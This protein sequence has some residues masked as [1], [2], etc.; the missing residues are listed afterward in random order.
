MKNSV[1]IQQ[2]QEMTRS[3]LSARLRLLNRMVNS[4]YDG[5]LREYSIKASQVSILAM[6]V[7]LG[8]AHC[9]ELCCR[10]QMDSSTF[11]RA[12]A[13]LRKSGW[14]KS[15]ASGD[16][17]ILKIT[18]TKEGSELLSQVYPLWKH[19]QDEAF[20]FLGEK[21]AEGLQD[22]RVPGEKSDGTLALL[23]EKDNYQIK[24]ADYE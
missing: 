13:R 20:A 16:G 4:I 3:C 14:L 15:E 2:V 8:E 9:K 5:A 12:L 11:S 23:R 6:V 10:L 19:A 1:T 22:T 21:L 17:K 18:I 24:R 7:E